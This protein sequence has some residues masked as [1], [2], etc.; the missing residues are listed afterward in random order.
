MA[1]AYDCPYTLENTLLV[2]SNALYIPE[3]NHNL[4]Y[5]FILR[6]AGLQVDEITKL[7]A[8]EPIQEN[9]II[10]DAETKLRI[11]LKL[12]G[13]FSYFPYSKL[14]HNETDKWEERNVVFLT[15]DK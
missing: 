3:M 12:K 8:T 1:I 4:I 9:H 13:V 15:P 6:D 10:Y 7:H 5:P 11:H 2:I 14:T